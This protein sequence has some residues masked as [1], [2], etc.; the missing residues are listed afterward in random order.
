MNQHE[1]TQS[2]HRVNP[3]VVEPPPPPIAPLLDQLDTD[4]RPLHEPIAAEHRRRRPLPRRRLVLAGAAAGGLALAVFIGVGAS[5][6]GTQ[7]VL[8]EVLRATTPGSGVL[9]M[10]T[11]TE[12]TAAGTTNTI[13]DEVWTAQNPRRLHSII[14]IGGEVT[15]GALTTTPVRSLSW[16]GANPTSSSRARPRTW[17]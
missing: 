13:R 12:N 16:W 15:E 8:A 6:G 3:V 4:V 14:T 11:V 9:H 10:L 2:L 1:V 5:G 7:N 17:R